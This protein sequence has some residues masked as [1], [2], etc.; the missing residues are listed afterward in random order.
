MPDDTLQQLLAD[1]TP[2]L[3]SQ[4]QL[5][6]MPALPGAPRSVAVLV[7]GTLTIF[8]SADLDRAGQLREVVHQLGHQLCTQPANTDWQSALTP[9]GA[10]DVAQVLA[11]Q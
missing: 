11:R 8:L 4:V 1:L 3:G 7:N 5:A 6:E 9:M 10:P 2:S